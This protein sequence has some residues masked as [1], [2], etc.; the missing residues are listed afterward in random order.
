MNKQPVIGIL[1]QTIEDPMKNDTRFDDYTSYI[2][3]DVVKFMEGQGARVVPLVY[4]TPNETTLE[5]LKHID[6]VLMPGGDGDD[7]G[8]GRYVF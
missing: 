2:M 3:S 7:F 8:L 5:I 6:G 1:S 4:G